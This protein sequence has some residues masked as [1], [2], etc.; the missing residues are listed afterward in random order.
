ML[1]E[2][3]DD[4]ERDASEQLRREHDALE[5][6]GKN[7]M[8]KAEIECAKGDALAAVK[9]K[10]SENQVKASRLKMEKEET[11]Q[12][13]QG[14][15]RQELLNKQ[16]NVEAARKA[17]ER[18]AQEQE[19]RIRRNQQT[20]QDIKEAIKEALESKRQQELPKRPPRETIEKPAKTLP[21]K[22]IERTTKTI[23]AKTTETA[24]P[25]PQKPFCPLR[26]Y[27]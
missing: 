9:L 4:H 19:R 18:I 21:R 17:K 8:K 12:I 3:R 11:A 25:P 14:T 24:K 1:I 15:L 16:N 5:Q 2:L 7:C 26:L 23:P 6:Q 27:M 20:K 13:Q 22:T 10:N